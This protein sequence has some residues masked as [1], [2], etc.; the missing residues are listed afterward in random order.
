V[1]KYAGGV[2]DNYGR[3]P[4]K[5]FSF[6]DIM[7]LLGGKN[8]DDKKTPV[9]RIALVPVIGPIMSGKN[10][11]IMGG[12]NTVFDLTL[13]AKLAEL[14]RDET[15][16]AVVLRIDSPGGSALASDNIWHAVRAL[17][18][19]KPVVASMG[20]IAA[21]GGYYIASAATEVYAS[22][23]T[24]TGSI[25]VV[26]GKMVFKDA[27]EKVG[28]KSE[29]LQ[30]G[31][32]AGLHSPLSRFTEDERLLVTNLMK[33]AYDLFVD[34]VSEGRK[35]KRDD[36][37]KIAEGR[38]WTGSQAHSHGLVNHLGGISAA[39]ARARILAAVPEGTPIEVMPKPKSLMELVG[40]A[41]SEPEAR[42]TRTVKQLHP[43]ITFGLSISAL[44]IH[45]RVLAISPYL[46]S[47]R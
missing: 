4:A 38:V 7:K 32:N 13:T 1:A 20:D 22:P 9:Q 42:V 44:L 33:D 43:S 11:E 23:A 5:Q 31:K 35:L 30:T 39:L 37:L 18:A 6:S 25:G 12:T 45:E 21:S 15:V 29:R 28:I 34:R 27:A 19:K 8:G 16:R 10:E 41:F 24:L 2:V 36:V 26:G 17:A 40:E 47:V 14:S 46:V 3:P